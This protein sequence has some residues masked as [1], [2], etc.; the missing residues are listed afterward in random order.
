MH[1]IWLRQACEV[2]TH[3][4]GGHLIKI[5]G[6]VGL[7]VAPIPPPGLERRHNGAEVDVLGPSSH[8]STA[9]V[10]ILRSRLVWKCSCGFRQL[11]A[12]PM[13]WT[14][15]QTA[16]RATR[17]F[18]PPHSLRIV[19]ARLEVVVGKCTKSGKIRGPSGDCDFTRPNGPCVPKIGLV[20]CDGNG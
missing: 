14:N 17:A 3:C 20:F 10:P 7:H 15:C 9:A 5:P 8:P 13:T 12:R 19:S 18:L 1:K 16:K 2:S 6:S 4:S 11:S